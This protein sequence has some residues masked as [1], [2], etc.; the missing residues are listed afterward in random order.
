MLLTI[1]G[2]GPVAIATYFLGYVA[3]RR[4]LPASVPSLC[5]AGFVF[6]LAAALISIGILITGL[7][8]AP[9]E[10]FTERSGWYLLFT[11]VAAMASVPLLYRLRHEGAWRTG[12][13]LH[14]SAGRSAGSGGSD[15]L[16]TV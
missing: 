1:F 2:G 5:L 15:L 14:D 10:V 8:L 3:R 4:S 7:L 11:G 16:L 6:Q 13:V 9:T 12:G